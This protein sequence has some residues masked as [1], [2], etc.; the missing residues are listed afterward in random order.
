V[1]ILAVASKLAFSWYGPRCMVINAFAQTGGADVKA[2]TSEDVRLDPYLGIM[3]VTGFMAVMVVGAAWVAW[4]VWP[5]PEIPA[6]TE[7]TQRV[8]GTA[9]RSRG[10]ERV[11]LNFGCD[12]HADLTVAG[13]RHRVWTQSYRICGNFMSSSIG[14]FE[15]SLNRSGDYVVRTSFDEDEVSRTRAEASLSEGISWALREFDAKQAARRSWRARKRRCGRRDAVTKVDQAKGRVVCSFSCGAASAVATKLALSW[16][17]ERCTVINA[18]VQNEHADNRRFLS[19]CERWFGVPIV[20][21]R[22]Q[23]YDADIINVFRR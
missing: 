17:G 18:F 4:S 21:V 10:I 15:V 22:D 7:Y 23:K 20:V 5:W 3:V 2:D 1:L 16:Y 6:L 9:F 19:D 12:T 8:Y 11:R 13:E 14:D